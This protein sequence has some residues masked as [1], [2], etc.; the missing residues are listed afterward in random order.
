MDTRIHDELATRRLRI[1][2]YRGSAHGANEFPFLIVHTG[3]TVLPV[4]SRGLAHAVS[5]KRLSS[6]IAGPDQMLEGT[7]FCKGSSILVS[8]GPGTGKTTLGGQFAA[9]ACGRG[10]RCLVFAFEES[11]PHMVR[12]MRTVGIDRQP[13][14]DDK[15]LTV[16]SV[17]PSLQGLEMHLA[18]VLHLVQTVRPAVVVVDPLSAL[19]VIVTMGQSQI[20]VLRLI[21]H[22]KGI[23][24]TS[25][26]L[27]TRSADDA[28]DLNISSLMDTWIAVKNER[29]EDGRYRCIYVAKS[30]GMAHSS[31][32]RQFAISARGIEVVN[33]KALS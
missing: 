26:F 22:P 8:G 7:G 15:Q 9:A 24:A 16:H 19:Q 12:N 2:K 20:M 29:L 25:L 14:I 23:G 21:D 28:T 1:V 11:V 18:S 32:V 30:R 33:R 17:R 5:D 6:G 4:T 10:D 31:D 27:T 13:L 3:N